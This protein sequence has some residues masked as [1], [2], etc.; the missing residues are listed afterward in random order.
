MAD[1]LADA[2]QMAFVCSFP[3]RATYS[4]IAAACRGEFGVPRAWS[5]AEIA[6][7][8]SARHRNRRRLTLD[9]K[10]GVLAYIDDRADRWTLDEIVAGIAK[11]HKLVVPRSTVYDEVVRSRAR[12]V[13]SLINVARRAAPP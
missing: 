6:V 2:E 5:V 4:E 7:V 8:W 9:D 3:R 10:P 11:E 12:A 1:R 13:A